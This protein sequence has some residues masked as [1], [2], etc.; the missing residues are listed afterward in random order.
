MRA[1]RSCTAKSR[2][3]SA[4]FVKRTRCFPARTITVNYTVCPTWL[5]HPP[6]KKKKITFPVERS[7]LLEWVQFLPFPSDVSFFPV[8]NVRRFNRND[9]FEQFRYRNDIYEQ[10]TIVVLT[11]TRRRRY[12]TRR[13]PIPFQLSTIFERASPPPLSRPKTRNNFRFSKKKPI[14]VMITNFAYVRMFPVTKNACRP[15][16][17]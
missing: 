11:T 16:V 12:T 7:V 13:F 2:T 3:R 1:I 4:F 8:R 9:Y 14:P 17:R 15:S 10:Y 6:K 5:I